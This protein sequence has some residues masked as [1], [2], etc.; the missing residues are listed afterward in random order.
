MKYLTSLLLLISPTLQAQTWTAE[1]VAK[2]QKQLNSN[3]TCKNMVQEY[4]GTSELEDAMDQISFTFSIPKELD[5][6]KTDNCNTEKEH[7]TPNIFS[8]GEYVSKYA[9]CLDGSTTFKQPKSTGFNGWNGFCGET[10][11]S[12]TMMMT[13]NEGW[14]PDGMIHEYTTDY[15]PGSRPSSVEYALNKLAPKSKDHC[16]DTRW[17]YYNTADSG[18]EYIES[19][20]DGLTSPSQFIRKR[21]DGTKLSR[22]PVP[23]MIKTPGEKT[24]HWITVVDIIGHDSKKNIETNKECM[25]VVNQWHRQYKIPCK[26]L[27]EMAENVGSSYLGIGG[28]A[29]G[30]YI[31]VKQ[32]P[33]TVKAAARDVGAAVR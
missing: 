7:R 9:I 28:G 2:A 16:K 6:Y 27:A 22:A 4:L 31:R 12:N 33:N 29:V 26:H 32:K 21:E 18:Q 15:T 30:K 8:C 3:P 5:L 1:V 25:A 24:L 14:H 17:S 10:A 23:V 19:I 11:I 13:C 20:V